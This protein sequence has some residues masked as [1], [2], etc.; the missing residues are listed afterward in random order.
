MGRPKTFSIFR[1]EFLRTIN[2]VGFVILT[3]ALPVLALLGIGIFRIVTRESTPHIEE[4]RIGYV[5]QAGGFDRFSHQG[6]I[7]FIPF[8]SESQARSALIAKEIKEYAVIPP[9]FMRNGRIRLYATQ[10]ELAPSEAL[11]AALTGFV[12]SNLLAGKVSPETVARVQ[13]PLDLV[14]TTLDS[15]GNLAREQGGYGNFI[16]PALFS[17][18]LA[19]SLSFTSGYMLQGL[20]EEKENRL[21]EVLLSSVSTRQLLVGKVLGYG[22]AGLLQVAVWAVSIPLLLAL[23]A[24][25]F[26]GILSGI[27]LP[28]GFW[29]LGVAYFILGYSLFAV[30]SAS[31]ASVSRTVREAQGLVP[32]FTLFSIAPFWFLSLLMIFPGNP[33]WVV[34]SIFPLS[35]PVLV[36]LRMGIT[37]VPAWQLLASIAVLLGCIVG[38]LI[39]A[40]KLL[41]LYL[42]MYGRRPNL[43]EIVRSLRSG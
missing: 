15:S 11:R 42:L 9:A 20:S 1:Y 39:V 32:I 17:L 5:D 26:G 2:R 6:Q 10:R 30:I 27:R 21:I 41:N 23:A 37:G 3:L 7:T 16:V 4:T 24:S 14:M 22:C 8:Q 31:V 29:M 28:V 40:A 18:L 43:K 35:A 36:L 13:V 34:F 38:G 25:S 33:V 19:L 12:S